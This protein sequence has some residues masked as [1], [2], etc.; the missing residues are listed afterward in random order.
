MAMF[1]SLGII[2]ALVDLLFSWVPDPANFTIIERFEDKIIR[3]GLG[4]KQA[5]IQFQDLG[6]LIEDDKGFMAK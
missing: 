1:L 4:L 3:K 2:L 5:A 6:E